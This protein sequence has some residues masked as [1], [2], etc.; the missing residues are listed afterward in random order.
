MKTPLPLRKK[1]TSFAN[2][3]EF[4]LVNI[5]CDPVKSREIREYHHGI[6][7]RYHIN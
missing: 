2:A 6:K 3:N 1:V 5:K 7:P 4:E